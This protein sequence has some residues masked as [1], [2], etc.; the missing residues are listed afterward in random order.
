ME[1]PIDPTAFG[2]IKRPDQ[3]VTMAATDNLKFGVLIG[4]VEVGQVTNKEV[5]N[6][7]LHLILFELLRKKEKDYR[8]VYYCSTYYLLHKSQRMDY[9]MEGS[10]YRLDLRLLYDNVGGGV[11]GA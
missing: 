3:V 11:V 6:T 8:Y 10:G 9:N 4:L 5:V 1:D 7:V 2:D